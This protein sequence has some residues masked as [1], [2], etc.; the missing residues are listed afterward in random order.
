[1]AVRVVALLVMHIPSH[2]LDTPT[3]SG[4]WPSQR[5]RR[6]A[7]WVP[8][9]GPNRRAVVVG[10]TEGVG[11]TAEGWSRRGVR[12]ILPRRE[13]LHRAVV[14]KADIPRILYRS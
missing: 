3:A 8:T 10:G 12:R 14:R 13:A 9:L 4:W 7:P 6:A 11:R 5:R 2:R 1:M